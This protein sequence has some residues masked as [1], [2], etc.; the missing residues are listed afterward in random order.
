M[1][2]LKLKYSI[3]DS[4]SWVDDGLQLLLFLF[5]RHE[6]MI[7]FEGFLDGSWQHVLIVYLQSHLRSNTRPSK[8]PLDLLNLFSGGYIRFWNLDSGAS[9]FEAFPSLPNN[10]L[11]LHQILVGSCHVSIFHLTFILSTLWASVSIFVFGYPALFHSV[12]GR[13]NDDGNELNKIPK[14][15]EIR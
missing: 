10:S 9:I 14:V 2:H 5:L 7:I 6:I 8:E 12:D 13:E 3:W 11:A 4:E 15:I 1:W